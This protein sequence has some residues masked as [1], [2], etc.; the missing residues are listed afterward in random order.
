MKLIK[1][2]HDENFNKHKSLANKPNDAK[3]N[4]YLVNETQGI[5]P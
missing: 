3:D 4:E 5:P 2:S 1:M